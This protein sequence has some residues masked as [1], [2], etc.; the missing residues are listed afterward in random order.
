MDSYDILKLSTEYGAAHALEVLNAI[1]P[2]D[3]DGSE[4]AYNR[5]REM[6]LQAIGRQS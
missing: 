1:N 4:A 6:L 5:L 3:F 2:A